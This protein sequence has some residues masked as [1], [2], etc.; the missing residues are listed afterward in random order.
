[1]TFE[2]ILQQTVDIL[3]SRGRVS[4][5]ALQRQFELD[6]AYLEDLKGELLYAYPQVVD[7]KG[8]GLVWTGEPTV[9]PSA[10]V[11]ASPLAGHASVREPRVYTPQHLVERILISHAALE[12][13]RKQVTVLFCDLAN[14]T[15]LAEQ[16][17][18]EIMHTVL[19]QFFEL[20]LSAVHR[21]EGTINQFLGDGFMALFGA[22]LAHED[23]ARR[24]VLAALEL[25]RQLQAYT[26]QPAQQHGVEL[27]LRMGLNTGIVVVG[28][29]GDNLR[30]DYTAVG[31]TTNVAAR[32]EQEAGPNQIV[33]S[34]TTHRLVVGYCRTRTLG[35][36]SL[37]GKAQPVHVWEVTEA[38]EARTRMD[39]EI[40]RGLTP[41]VGRERELQALHAGFVQARAGYGQAV[42]LVGEAGIGKSRLLLEFRRQIETTEVTWLEGH[43]MSFGQAMVFHPV[44]ELLKRNFQ[45]EEGDTDATVIAKIEQAVLHLG[46]DLRPIMPYLR[47]LLAVDPGDE[48]VRSMNPQLRRAELFDA[49]QRWLVRAAEFQPQVLVLEDLHWIDPATEAFLRATVDRIPTARV[50]ILCTYRPGYVQ[51]LGERTYFT[52]L[53]LPT[54][55]TTDSVHMAEAM[56]GS[57]RLPVDLEA[58]IV[59]K[60]EG[61]PFFVEEVVKSLREIG[62]IRQVEDHYI[63]SQPI[64][65]IVV[66]N[67]IQDVLMARI[68]RLEEAP[69]TTLQLAAVIGREFTYRLLD[70]L[71]D[72]RDQTETYLQELKA[73]EL[74]YETRLY[75]EL[76]YMFKHALTQ[77][78][79]Y[80]SLLTHRR[81][82]L[83]RLIGQAMEE[84]YAD[85]LA[86]H[87]EMLAYHYAKGNAWEKALTYFQQAAQKAV[88]A[89]ATREAVSLYDQAFEA[90]RHLGDAV[91]TETLMAMHQAK[92][93]LYYVL[94]EFVQARAESE[95]ILAYARQAQDE[96]RIGEALAGMASASTFAHDFDQAIEEAKQAI[97]SAEQIDARTILASSYYT[98]GFVHTVTGRHEEA[99]HELNQSL[100]LSQSANVVA[101]QS[102]AL[103]LIGMI[104]NWEGDYTEGARIISQGLQVAREHELMV[105]LLQNLFCYGVTLTG[106]GDYEQALSVLE[107]GLAFSAKVGAEV[108]SHRLLNSLG[109]LYIELGALAPALDFNQRGAEGARTRG[110]AET[111]ANAEMNLAD[112]FL[113]QGDLT[114]AYELLHGVYRVVKDPATSPWNRFRYSTH[115]FASMGELWLARGD[116]AQAQEFANQCIEQA[117]RINAP[118]YVVKGLRL[119]GDIAL[120]RRQWDEAQRWLGQALPLA[121]TIGN[122]TQLWKTHLALGRLHTAVHQPDKARQAYQ[123]AR[124]VIEHMKAHVQHPELL[125]SLEHSILFQEV[126]D[127]SMAN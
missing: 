85:R 30:M 24:A 5:R 13:E 26:T 53:A 49:L 93:D 44:I 63:L 41:F 64:E 2:E 12:G 81:Q 66:P 125:A 70:R 111:I 78:V 39:V 10:P 11:T 7:D 121:Q 95:K 90:A 17:G 120:A 102:L 27:T 124:N 34:E 84:L 80:N 87:C 109:W 6:D 16:L 116:T 99:K 94:S 88:E 73:I 119:Q 22:P 29:I 114:L 9:V 106:K 69:R 75:P 31:D 23:H 100:S 79:A 110:H 89:F 61:N 55:S 8:R 40:E 33:I 14:S 72:L 126:Y 86:E 21:Y 101:H 71:A 45:I 91:A 57:G 97:E 108:Y 82:D 48:T 92:S 35:A 59:Q 42:F 127:L 54:L 77:D 83:H 1:M 20:A 123:A 19:N 43:A 15:G 52:R 74:I 28:A 36:L 18:P 25:R 104:K 117:T 67:T 3:Q 122:P 112:V 115:L 46:E 107:E 37:K 51:P 118:K 60:A 103:S 98:M 62:A 96:Y 56:L 68:D 76:A 4:Y 32:L 113:V 38:R 58:L 50:L 105:P 65:E 47:Y